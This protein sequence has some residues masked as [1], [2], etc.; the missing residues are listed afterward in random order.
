MLEQKAVERAEKRRGSLA[1]T[2]PAGKHLSLAGVS[3]GEMKR[4]FVLVLRM[5]E[6]LRVDEAKNKRK[7][8]AKGNED[9]EYREDETRHK[10]RCKKEAKG[11]FQYRRGSEDGE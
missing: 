8:K 2:Y 11:D 3:I 9:D 4:T 5:R 1:S 7:K 6:N 10:H